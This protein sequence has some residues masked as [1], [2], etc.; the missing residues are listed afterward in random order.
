M[1]DY[2]TSETGNWNIAN[3][4]ANEMIFKPFYE[5]SQYKTIAKF[6][7][8]DIE[9]DFT[10][11]DQTKVMS[12]IK[13]LNWYKD[14]MEQGIRQCLFAIRNSN[15]K[16]RVQDFLAEIIDL[17]KVLEMVS[18]K[19][20]DRDKYKININ[21]DAFNL[22]YNCLNRIFTEVTEPMNKSDL[23]FNYREQ[24]DPKKAKKRIKDDFITTG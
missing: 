10:F 17:N 18:E 16:K 19:I 4:W 13:A 7:C 20:V 3:N 24:F 5:A 9:E 11:D 8:S 21:E 12:R 22:V 15:D 14:K 2:E 23:I 6:G 1:G